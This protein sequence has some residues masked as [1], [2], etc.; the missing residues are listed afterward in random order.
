[1]RGSLARI[2]INWATSTLTFEDGSII[3]LGRRNLPE[4]A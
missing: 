4:A 1:M 2:R 3:W